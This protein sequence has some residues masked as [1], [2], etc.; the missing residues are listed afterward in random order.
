VG[1]VNNTSGVEQPALWVLSGGAWT[2]TRPA[3][4]ADAVGGQDAESYAVSCG[5]SVCAAVG[6]YNVDSTIEWTAWSWSGGSWAAP[7]LVPS[8]AGA[9][10]GLRIQSAS[11]WTDTCLIYEAYTDTSNNNRT[12]VWQD[13]SG[14]WNPADLLLPADAQPGSQLIVDG[15]PCGWGECLVSAS[16][17]DASYNTH[18]AWWVWTGSAWTTITVPAADDIGFDMV[19]CG[20]GV[21]A[22]ESVSQ[23]TL[24]TWTS[25]STSVSSQ[26]A[27]NA[28]TLAYSPPLSC[29]AGQCA[30]ASSHADTSGASQNAILIWSG[31]SWT[32]ADLSAPPGSWGFVIDGLTCGAGQCLAG[33][34]YANSGSEQNQWWSLPGG[35]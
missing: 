8:D 22:A 19:S 33:A 27:P 10:P 23:G 3:L 31:G 13:L 14:S 12:V 7:A 4:P 35:N 26:P 6:E 1:Y 2:V 32:T 5:S 15:A 34:S 28:D 21:C 18:K 25:G 30:V 16:Y 24:W 17:F 20:S 29:G 11:C 9:A